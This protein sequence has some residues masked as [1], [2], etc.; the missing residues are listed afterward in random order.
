MCTVI[1]RLEERNFHLNC[2]E[3]CRHC[4]V[5]NLREFSTQGLLRCSM[6]TTSKSKELLNQLKTWRLWNK[7]TIR[8][9][10]FLHEFRNVWR[11]AWRKRSPKATER[12]REHK[13]TEK[14]Y[15]RW[16]DQ[17]L[18]QNQTNNQT[19][20]PLEIDS[21]SR[22]VIPDMQYLSQMPVNLSFQSLRFE[23]FA[24][25]TSWMNSWFS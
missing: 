5:S 16:N 7:K 8:H 14:K 25:V 20:L 23:R 4:T 18:K 6:K 19:A 9:P 10:M 24:V 22:I 12:E 11:Q 17:L 3:I 13:N 2:N 21:I 1:E 15:F